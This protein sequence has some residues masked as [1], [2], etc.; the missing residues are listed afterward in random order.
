M[1]KKL[2]AVESSIQ[3]NHKEDAYPGLNEQGIIFPITKEEFYSR[4]YGL[5]VRAVK[6][7]N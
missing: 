4:Y 6:S 5:S 2:K 3:P 7:I 1:G